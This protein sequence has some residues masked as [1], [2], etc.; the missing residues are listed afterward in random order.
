MEQ[1]PVIVS[2]KI[3]QICTLINNNSRLA[4]MFRSCYPNTLETTTKLIDDGTTYVFT[5]DIPAMWLRDSSAQIKHYIPLAKE[6]IQVQRIIEGLIKRQMKYILIDPYAN[7]FN[8]E[9]NGK[10]FHKDNT[11]VEDNPWVWERKYEIDSLC[12][13]IELA[14]LYWQETARDSIFNEKF[15][16]VVEKIISLWK[17]E[18]RHYENSTYY[19]ERTNCRQ[20]DTLDNKGRGRPT[21]YTGMTWTGFRPSDDVCTYGY[22][23]PANMFAVVV[24]GYIVEIADQVYEDNSLKEKAYQLKKE[25]DQGIQKEGIYEHPVYGKIY[26][27]ETDGYGN[28][29]LMDDA[30]VPS[31]LSIPYLGYVSVEDPIYQNTRSFILSK[32][33]PYYF[34]GKYAAG[35]GSPHKPDGYIWHISLV[36]QA[37]TSKDEKEIAELLRVIQKTDAGTNF[38]HE[39]FNVDNPHEY[40]RPWFAWANSLFAEL[41]LKLVNNKIINTI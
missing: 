34:E 35:I 39:G 31:L 38:M 16:I 4:D 27:Y 22:L 37:L 21:K 30:N 24:L 1:L 8:K 6:D 32:E 11:D 28:Y 40:T 2:E 13:P 18:Q 10:C 25:I 36:I 9:A 17:T 29:N 20:I 26:A 33:N 15:K 41:I 7:A 19:F 12:Y 3:E 14:Y 23:I 5:G